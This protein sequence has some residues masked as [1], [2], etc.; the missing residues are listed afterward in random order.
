VSASSAQRC[1]AR[2]DDTALVRR[3]GLPSWAGVDSFLMVHSVWIVRAVTSTAVGTRSHRLP[4]SRGSATF[5]EEMVV[6][7]VFW[8]G[9]ERGAAWEWMVLVDA[10][11]G[12]SR[13]LPVFGWRFGRCSGGRR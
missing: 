9:R 4:L 5:Y 3:E 12:G 1:A 6:A 8:G 11:N 2:G 7:G 10:D 13:L